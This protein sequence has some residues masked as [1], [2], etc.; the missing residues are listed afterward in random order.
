M[1]GLIEQQMRIHAY[2]V[3]CLASQSHIKHLL[4]Q[5]KTPLCKAGQLLGTHDCHWP[6]VTGIIALHAAQ[7]M[8]ALGTQHEPSQGLAVL[9]AFKH[10][11]LYGTRPLVQQGARV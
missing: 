3:P 2:F 7:H 11:W 8:A 1:G 4:L 10:A 5:G 6:V 9:C